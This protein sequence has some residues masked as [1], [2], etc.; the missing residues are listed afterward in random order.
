MKPFSPTP[1]GLLQSYTQC[2]L[3][4]VI[5][6]YKIKVNFL[7][8]LVILGIE[9]DRNYDV[10]EEKMQIFYSRLRIRDTIAVPLYLL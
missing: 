7:G 2:L 3:E 4:L 6:S 5:V 10:I 8:V 1:V 9:E